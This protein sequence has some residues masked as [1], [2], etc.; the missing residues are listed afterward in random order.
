MV[1][2][3]LENPNDIERELVEKFLALHAESKRLASL[4]EEKKKE[5]DDAEAK[6]LE[7]LNDE[8]KKASARYEGLGHVTCLDPVVGYANV[9]ADK[10]EELFSFL[11][12]EDR[13]DL[14]KTAVH[15]SS[16]KAFI[17]QQLKEG[18]EVPSYVQVGMVQ[19]LR[20]YPEK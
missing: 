4:A 19:R 6:L 3:T 10:E 5:R 9:P 13:A 2:T 8:G 12:K 14:I 18:K 1:E 11:K 16:L 15:P 20:A 7:L 17:S